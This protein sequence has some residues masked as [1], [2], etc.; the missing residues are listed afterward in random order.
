MKTHH[1]YK[2]IIISLLTVILAGCK[3]DWLDEKSDIARIVPTTMEDMRLLL[4]DS[5]L[6]LSYTSLGEFSA[7]DVFLPPAVLSAAT[8]ME[9]NAYTWQKDIFAGSTG[10]LQWNTPYK[11]VLLTN[12]VL[13]GLEKIRPSADQQ[14][15]WNDLKG[16]ALF[17]RAKAFF[18]LVTLFAK[19]YNAQTASSDEG[20][21]IRL[22]S[23]IHAPVVRASL[24]QSYSQILSDLQEAVR[25]MKP[26]TALKTEPSKTSANAFLARVYLSMNKYDKALAYS[27]EC[28]KL[29][30][31]LIDY[32]SVVAG[33]S[34]FKAFNDE[35]LFFSRHARLRVL[36]SSRVASELYN[37]YDENDLRKTHF[38]S[39]SSGGGYTFKGSYT[40][41]ILPFGGFAVNEMY[42][43]RA[44]CLARLGDPEGAVDDLNTLLVKRY[45]QGTFVPLVPGTADETLDIV[46]EERRKELVF[47]GLRWLDL[48]RLNQNPRHA[49]TLTRVVDGQSFS[50]PPGDPKYVFPIPDYIISSSNISQNPR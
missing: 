12:V 22:K 25:L 48:R 44:E 45:K 39:S 40:G 4:N 26:Y 17:F 29:Y 18:D 7:D 47:T 49:R 11:Q 31:T 37:T 19:P 15:E 42:L 23:D 50:L 2:Y 13:E 5:D 24:E 38:F 46:L 43:T 10:V 27:N 35:T 41:S 6:Q 1:K 8:N 14:A 3:K 34:P 21:P 36:P 20:I 33:G 9:R 30:S 32:N 16:R 28:L